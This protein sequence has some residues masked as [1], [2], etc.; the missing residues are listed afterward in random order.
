MLYNNIS[1]DST[2]CID[3]PHITSVCAGGGAQRRKHNRSNGPHSK[4]LFKSPWLGNGCLYVCTFFFSITNM[5]VSEYHGGLWTPTIPE[6]SQVEQCCLGVIFYKVEVFPCI[7]PGPYL[8]LLRAI[9]LVTYCNLK[10]FK[11][12]IAIQLNQKS[13]YIQEG[14]RIIFESK[15]YSYLIFYF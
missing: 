2:C 15:F 8:K 3:M 10:L 4:K 14:L 6:A 13:L 5:M 1:I 12:N 9:C 7:V 11:T